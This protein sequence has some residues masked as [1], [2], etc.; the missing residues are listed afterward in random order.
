MTSGSER[1]GVRRLGLGAA[2]EMDKTTPRLPWQADGGDWPQRERLRLPR[3]ERAVQDC[4]GQTPLPL[5][6]FFRAV[7]HCLEITLARFDASD[8]HNTHKASPQEAARRILL[9]SSDHDDETIAQWKM[10]K[11]QLG[12]QADY[13]WGAWSSWRPCSSR[14]EVHERCRNTEGCPAHRSGDAQCRSNPHIVHARRTSHSRYRGRTVSQHPSSQGESP[15]RL[16]R[17]E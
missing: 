6:Y 4:R 13:P 2:S 15:G 14:G 7:W 12:V 9:P 10:T 8:K 17:D 3:P 16:R 5:R 11:K 1:H